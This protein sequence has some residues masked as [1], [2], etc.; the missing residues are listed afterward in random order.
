MYALMDE[1]PGAEV[2]IHPDPKGMY[3]DEKYRQVI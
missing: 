1:F 3:E 2:L